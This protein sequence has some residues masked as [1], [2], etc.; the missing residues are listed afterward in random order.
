MARRRELS[1]KRNDSV[2]L[3]FPTQGHSDEMCKGEGRLPGA[4]QR[5]A[6]AKGK[7]GVWMPAPWLVVVRS[8]HRDR[9]GVVVVVVPVTPV[10]P[11]ATEAASGH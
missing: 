2:F 7:R 11:V 4:T 10:I 1:G 6:G 5:Q 9:S 3:F 8:G